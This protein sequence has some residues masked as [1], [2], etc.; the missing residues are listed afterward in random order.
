MGGVV[1][2]YKCQRQLRTVIAEDRGAGAGRKMP[3]PEATNQGRVTNSHIHNILHYSAHR[4]E[5]FNKHKGCSKTLAR[6]PK[7]TTPG[8]NTKVA[9]KNTRLDLF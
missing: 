3:S 7:M 1:F 6:T 4:N 5:G 9:N 2:P 8:H